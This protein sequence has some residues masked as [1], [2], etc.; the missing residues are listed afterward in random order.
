MAGTGVGNSSNKLYIEASGSTITPLIGGDFSAAGR[1]VTINGNLGV[2]TTTIGNPSTP[3]VATAG[4]VRLHVSGGRTILDQEDWTMFTY[5][6]NYVCNGASTNCGYFR[7]SS[8]IVR[9]K[10]QLKWNTFPVCLASNATLFNLP[11]GY[12]PLGGNARRFIVPTTKTYTTPAPYPQ[13]TPYTYSITINP[14]GAVQIE[15]STCDVWT[16][17]LDSIAFPTH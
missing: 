3:V 12:R 17:N 8:G 14:S 11:L 9:F 7:D 13:E 1:Y 6:L 2:G 4:V 10:G 5:S 16:F 15:Y